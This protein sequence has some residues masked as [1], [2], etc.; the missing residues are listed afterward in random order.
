MF[1]T[2]NATNASESESVDIMIITVH[3]EID[4][5]SL[6]VIPDQVVAHICDFW[7]IYAI[8][9]SV[10]IIPCSLVIVYIDR[11]TNVIERHLKLNVKVILIPKP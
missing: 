3:S 6:C 10:V 5:S 9:D 7:G 4:P 11:F 1:T 8:R 2:T